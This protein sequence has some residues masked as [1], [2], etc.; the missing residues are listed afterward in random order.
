MKFLCISDQIDPI[1]YSKLIRE[2]FGDIDVVLFA[3]DLSSEYID[4]IVSSLNVPSFFVCGNHDTYKLDMANGA[5]Y[6]GGKVVRCKIDKQTTLLVAGASG[7]IRYNPG[8][9]QYTE[10]QM[11]FM[12][13]KMLPALLYNKIRYGRYIDVFLAHAPPYHIHDL[14]DSCHTGFKCFRWFAR[15]FS[16]AFMI[17][18]H[19]HLYDLQSE[20]CTRY[21]RTTIINAYSYY[22][23]ELNLSSKEAVRNIL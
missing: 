5:S 17:H 15:K 14:A 2:R 9:Y 6:I 22:V 21:H 4:F 8:Q 11:F 7:S 19:I 18:G 10:S 16:P 13:L 1:I 23:F 3:G 12:L 20:R